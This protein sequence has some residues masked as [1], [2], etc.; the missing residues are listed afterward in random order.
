MPDQGDAYRQDG[1]R[2]LPRGFRGKMGFGGEVDADFLERRKREREQALNKDSK[3][4]A[5][6]DDEEFSMRA[7]E[8]DLRKVICMP[9]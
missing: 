4:Y 6:S 3:I 8:A 5:S 2:D 9:V 1:G 7:R